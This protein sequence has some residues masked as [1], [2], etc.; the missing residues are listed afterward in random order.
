MTK[1]KLLKP[2]FEF[3]SLDRLFKECPKDR[4]LY[5]MIIG[6]RSNGKSF[7]VQEYSLREYLKNGSQM[8]FI[9]R[10]D[11]DWEDGNTNKVWEQF[12]SNPYRGNVI[13]EISKNKWNDIIYYRSCWYLIKRAE[14]PIIDDASGKRIEIGEIIEKDK[15]PFAYR[16]ALNLEE[17]YKGTAY[18]GIRNIL[19]DEFI[20]R[21]YYLRG[22][23]EF[24]LFTSLISTI[25]R[26]EDKARIFMLA[27][28]ISTSCPYFREMGI[29]KI[30]DMQ[31]GQI[32]IYEYGDSGLGL[33][34][35]YAPNDA[36]RNTK[37]KSNKYF[38]FENPKLKMITEGGW[39]IALYPHLPI[40]YEY[41]R[42]NILYEYFIVYEGETFHCEILHTKN[43][44]S[45]ITYIHRKT[46]PIKEDN[47]NMVYTPEHDIRPWYARRINKP[48]NRIMELILKL[49]V[50]EKIYYQDNEVGESIHHYID[51]CYNH[52]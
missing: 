6:E 29:R 48:S 27:N 2:E 15:K 20:T 38:A 44:E 36:V 35:E 3:Y 47:Q 8:A 32:D 17:H 1:Q 11:T 16:F 42:S 43:P 45:I 13:A 25:V 4:F 34:L 31:P 39:E 7:A 40:D 23:D 21:G 37:K 22:G 50:M 24:V 30:K 51:W 28:T 12:V 14:K 5:Y 19:F 18:P 33:A 41:S 52:A 9:R 46:T 26:L 10:W 49:F